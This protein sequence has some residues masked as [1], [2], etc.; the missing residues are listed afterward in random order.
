MLSCESAQNLMA[1][2]LYLEPGETL[3]QNLQLHL[4]DCVSCQNEYKEILA[5]KSLIEKAGL[6]SGQYEDIPERAALT[7]LY[8]NLLPE[9][10]RI[11]AQRY[12]E[13]PRQRFAPWSMA[14]GAIAASLFIFLAGFLFLSSN[15]TETPN[16]SVSQNASPE[17]MNYLIRAQVMLLQ[18]A[19]TESAQ[20][21]AFPIQQTVARN[22]A[23]EANLLNGVDDSPFANGERKLLRDIEFMLLQIANL[24]ET[25]MEEGVELLQRFL[26]ENGILFRIRLLEMRDKE[27]VI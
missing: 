7:R 20:D 18:I 27:I 4:Q 21:S 12:R 2:A 3:P 17:L 25:N 22:M 5:A 11:D 10:D 23:L 8:D 6:K 26:E 9:L 1:D 24:D 13:L 19:N 15:Q 16:Y 14:V